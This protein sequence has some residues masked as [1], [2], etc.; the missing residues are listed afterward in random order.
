MQKFFSK[1]L[2]RLLWSR[3]ITW[4]NMKLCQF[5]A[6]SLWAL[7]LVGCST[8]NTA[9]RAPEVVARLRQECEAGRQSSCADMVHVQQECWGHASFSGPNME[10]TRICAS[11][12]RNAEAIHPEIQA[13]LLRAQ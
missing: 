10:E 3:M 11:A 6:V 2:N 7:V 12:V 5:T 13:P 9:K 1:A 4:I 8:D